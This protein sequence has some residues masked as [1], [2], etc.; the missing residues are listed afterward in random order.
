MMSDR[1]IID[2]LHALDTKLYATDRKLAECVTIDELERD[3]R[4][5]PSF[6]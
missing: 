3:L 4:D 2:K 6:I 5:K 1:T